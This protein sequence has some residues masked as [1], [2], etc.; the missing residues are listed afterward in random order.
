MQPAHPYDLPIHT[1]QPWEV[2][3][4]CWV[5][6]VRPETL[7]AAVEAVGPHAGDVKQWLEAGH[8]PPHLRQ[9]TGRLS[10]SRAA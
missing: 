4:W 3:Y 2:S 1:D 8:P 10:E 5:L 6:D 9:V 7:S